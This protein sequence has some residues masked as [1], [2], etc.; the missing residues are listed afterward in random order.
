[1]PRLDIDLVANVARMER[2]MKRGAAIVD[3]TANDLKR[4]GGTLKNVFA[5]AGVGIGFGTITA[6]LQQIVE[7]AAEAE[8]IDNRLNAVLKATDHAA[9]LTAK[10][11]FTM[12]DGL[13]AVT[14]FDDE[15]IKEAQA[16]LLTFT[17]LSGENFERTLNAATGL[18]VVFGTDL[19]AATKLLGK[20]M[21]DP[22]RGISQLREAAVDLAPAQAELVKKFAEAGDKA[23]AQEIFLAALEG[24]IGNAAAG[25]N[26][27]LAGAT[28]GLTK[29]W[30]D[31]LESIGRTPEFQERT[32]ASLRGLTFALRAL[33]GETRDTRT[34]F[35]RLFNR[36]EDILGRLPQETPS[37]G[38]S[39]LKGVEGKTL[40]EID[41]EFAAKASAERKKRER[42]DAAAAALAKKNFDDIAKAAFDA[43]D[44]ER[45]AIE[46]QDEAID[47]L[48]DAVDPLRVLNKEFAELDRVK[49]RLTWDQYA[50]ATFDAF[51]KANQA[52]D[53]HKETADETFKA[54]E[55]AARGWGDEFTNTFADMVVDGKFRFRELIDS[56][57]RDLTRV[58]IFQSIT[59][60][61]FAGLGIPGFAGGGFFGGGLRLVGEQ[62]PELEAT[63]PARIWDA[64]KT[65]EMLSRSSGASGSI[66]VVNN[67]SMPAGASRAE[68]LSLLRASEERTKASVAEAVMRGGRMS[69]AF[70]S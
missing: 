33:T 5:F 70:G 62:G 59:K 19:T 63:G 23:K 50:A 15:A 35:E 27:G 68:M 13:A 4:I 65:Q 64:N 51:D 48:K 18:S 26:A 28:V 21:Q 12:A 22:V 53:D 69:A 52:L 45:E 2:D 42:E 47:K 55:A 38:G 39:L 7:K 20:A 61:L 3:K 29:A 58:V 1:M 41:A 36:P 16:A 44:K 37:R 34:E 67:L 49:E 57:I 10:Q 31:F 66:T 11:L 56:I 60:P 14:K 32:T 46:K 25:E 43:F 17:D 9:G 54:L 6:G 8:R 40:A 30:D 24:R